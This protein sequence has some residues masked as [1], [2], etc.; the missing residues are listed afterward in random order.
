M[1]LIIENSIVVVVVV[2]VVAV[3]VA[4]YEVRFNCLSILPR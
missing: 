4:G 2:V 1:L 3:A